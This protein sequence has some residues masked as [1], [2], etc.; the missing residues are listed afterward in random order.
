MR[1]LT[2]RRVTDRADLVPWQRVMVASYAADHVWLPADPLEEQ[3]PSLAGDVAGE[4]FELWVAFDGELPVAAAGMSMPLLDNVEAANIDLRVDPEHRRRGHGRRMLE[5]VLDRVR[6][7]GRRLVFAEVGE[8]LDGP[9]GTPGVAFAA[10]TSARRV[11]GEIRRVLVLADVDDMALA[12]LRVDAEKSAA[13]YTLVQWVDRAPER[14]YDDLA[15]LASRMTLDAPLGEMEWEP[16]RWDA[17]RYIETERRALERGRQRFTTAVVHD[18]SGRLVGYTDIGVNTE[19]RTV[20]YQWDTLVAPEH[21]GH[22]L[23]LLLKLANLEHLRSDP[24]PPEII[25]TWNAESNAHMVAI[26]EEIGFRPVDRWWEW[27]LDLA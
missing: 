12:K 17:A 6:A 10:S 21:R 11:L 16:E 22:R 20:A 4:R 8:P 5:Q 25:N 19:R 23:G 15:R 27:Q 14:W 24:R 3:A 7:H 26:N 13:G 1:A 2:L 9:G 18:G